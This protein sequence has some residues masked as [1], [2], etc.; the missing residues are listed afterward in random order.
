MVAY[1]VSPRGE[2]P[3]RAYVDSVASS[4]S[5]R[6]AA[7]GDGTPIRV[8]FAPYSSLSFARTLRNKREAILVAGSPL[9]AAA[10]N[11]LPVSNG[12]L[13]RVVGMLN[14]PEKGEDSFS[15]IAPYLEDRVHQ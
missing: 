6:L 5:R 10:L 9:K 2:C 12:E 4:V 8:K 3:S 7:D 13:D 14:D 1:I 11:F 15:I